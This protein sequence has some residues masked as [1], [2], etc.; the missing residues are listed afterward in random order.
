MAKEINLFI[1]CACTIAWGNNETSDEIRYCSLHAAA[2]D[3]L[4]ACEGLLEVIRNDDLV[5]E[6]VSYMREAASAIAKARGEAT[7][8]LGGDGVKTIYKYTVSVYTPRVRVPAGATVLFVGTDPGNGY[9]AIWMELD[10]EAEYEDRY[11]TFIGTGHD[12]PVGG[13][14]IGS[15][16]SDPFVW[17]VYEIPSPRTSD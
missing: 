16:I 1:D 3:L 8:I 10:P 11:Y 14:Y 4:T 15:T 13:R 6:S 7:Y 5:P 12:V 2:S 9:P 17:H